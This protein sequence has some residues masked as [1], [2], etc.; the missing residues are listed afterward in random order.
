MSWHLHGSGRRTRHNWRELLELDHG[1]TASW[2]DHRGYHEEPLPSDMPRT[3]HLWAWAPHTWL[4]VRIDGDHWWAALL[5]EG[6]PSAHHLWPQP[7]PTPPP[8]ITP[9]TNWGHARNAKQYKAAP[10][11]E[12]VLHRDDMIQLAPL[13]PTTGL[14]IGD[15]T[16]R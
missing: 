3:T 7:D 6:E 15:T 4:R 11:A 5:T 9:F 8:R 10:G 1:W 14:F 13:R 16:T 12:N 2:A